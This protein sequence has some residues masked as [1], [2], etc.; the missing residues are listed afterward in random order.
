MIFFLAIVAEN[1]IIRTTF[2]LM[3]S[4]SLGVDS[5]DDFSE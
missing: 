2:A 1:E 5:P 4:V 3:P